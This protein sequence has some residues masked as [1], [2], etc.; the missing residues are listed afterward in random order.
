[1]A[2]PFHIDNVQLTDLPE[3]QFRVA[4]QFWLDARGECVLPAASVI[5][6]L[7]LPRKLLPALVVF[8]VEAG[9]KQ[10]KFRLVGT[11]HVNATGVDLTGKFVEDV[12]GAEGTTK[13]MYAAVKSKAPYF[14]GGPLTWFSND[15]KS[16]MTLV[17]PFGNHSSEV[18]RFLAYNEFSA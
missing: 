6:P 3:G 11:A 13:R 14:Y 4:L 2:A 1:M 8:S 5:D 17:M 7:K 12:Q 9:L 15:F 10:L 18:T 16:Y